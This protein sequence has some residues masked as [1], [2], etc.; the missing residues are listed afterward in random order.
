VLD[1]D[2]RDI[3]FNP[4]SGSYATL[5]ISFSTPDLGSDV[6]F[7]TL[8]AS[9][10]RYW[11]S[12]LDFAVAALADKFASLRSMRQLPSS[13]FGVRCVAH[14]TYKV[15][16]SA[17]LAFTRIDAAVYFPIGKAF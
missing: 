6:S 17:D 8:K 15:N 1:Y 11:S 14:P 4:S 16:V 12:R 9:F 10:A 7:R 13:G 5:R 2:T 3:P